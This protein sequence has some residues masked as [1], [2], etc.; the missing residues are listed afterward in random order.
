MRLLCIGDA[1]SREGCDILQRKLG[2][3][4]RE[5]KVDFT[6]VNGENS[7]LGNGIDKDS[8]Q[9]ILDAGADLVT[10]G[11]HSFQKRSA[12]LLHQEEMWLLR[13][14]NLVNC[15]GTGV[16]Y[17]DCGSFV[18]RV[19]NLIGSLFINNEVNNPFLALD[20]ILA[21]NQ[22]ADVTVVDFHAEASGEKRA[23]GLYA[24]GRVSLIYGTHTHAR[25]DDLQ[26]LEHGTGYITDIGM[27]GVTN[28]VLGK[29][30]EVVIHNFKHP[31]N[32]MPIKDAKG[33]CMISGIVAEIDQKTGKCIRLEKVHVK[34]LR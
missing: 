24:D 34:D 21:D 27:T 7:A 13:P 18:L 28:S 25:T 2:I 26:I 33:A 6:I 22:R 9:R 12:P 4:K 1:V 20:E 16:K 10:G 29:D 19:I 8:Y 30:S 3:I 23:L 11:N 32:R 17:I 5:H 15:E 31:D 14:H